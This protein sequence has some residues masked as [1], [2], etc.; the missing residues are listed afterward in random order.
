YPGGCLIEATTLSE[1]RGTTRPFQLVGAPG[2]D[3][4]ELARALNARDLPGVAFVPTFFRPQFQKHAG[5]V[6]AGVHIEVT[7][8]HRFASYR[9]GLELMRAVHDQFPE[10]FGWRPEPY[11]FVCDRPAVDLLTGGPEAR[12][13]LEQAEGLSD[14][15]ASWRDDEREFLAER[16]EVLLYA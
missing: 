8:R 7:D 14:W 9:C 2:I 6:C 5:Q 15:M 1:G 11:E 10:A 13:A 4:G 3:A 16:R 12:T